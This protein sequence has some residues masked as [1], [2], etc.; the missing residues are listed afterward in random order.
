MYLQCR[1]DA[2]T[3][4]LTLRPGSQPGRFTFN[5]HEKAAQRAEEGLG[6]NV[7]ASG[8][9]LPSKQLRTALRPL[10]R[11]RRHETQTPDRMVQGRVSLPASSEP[12]SFDLDDTK[13][14]QAN[15]C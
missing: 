7:A 3:H 1:L 15:E 8:R 5:I 9:M 2:T 13:P 10:G 11:L 6:E 4:P 12:L 14:E